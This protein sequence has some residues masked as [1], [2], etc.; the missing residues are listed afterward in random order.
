MFGEEK[1]RTSVRDFA[2]E[3]FVEANTRQS[4]CFCAEEHA[5]H[6]ALSQQR[7]SAENFRPGYSG[8]KNAYC[9]TYNRRCGS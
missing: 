8:A 6:V 9:A 4:E 5:L 2:E 3:S 1:T 7:G